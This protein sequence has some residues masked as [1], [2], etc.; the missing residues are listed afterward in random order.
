MTNHGVLVTLGDS[1][2]R[3]DEF[4]Q[5]LVELLGAILATT[6]DRI[7][8][9]QQIESQRVIWTSSIRLFGMTSGTIYRYCSAGWIYSQ[10]GLR[11]S[12]GTRRR[13]LRCA[14]FAF[15]VPVGT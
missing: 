10:S 3:F 14:E 5:Y 11:R 9:K 7:N 13:S 4:D 12:V 1:P 6:L 15:E 8:Q 2:N